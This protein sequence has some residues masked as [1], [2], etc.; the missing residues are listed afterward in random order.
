MGSCGAGTGSRGASSGWHTDQLVWVGAAAGSWRAGAIAPRGTRRLQATA[1]GHPRIGGGNFSSRSSLHHCSSSHPRADAD[2]PGE[3]VHRLQH[4]A[5]AACG[6]HEH[7][8]AVA[9]GSEEVVVA[10]AAAAHRLQREAHRS[11][12]GIEHSRAERAVQTG[13][14]SMINCITAYCS[15]RQPTLPHLNGEGDAPGRAVWVQAFL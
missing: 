6:A 9:R 13:W 14:V 8:V 15:T 11:L 7:A 1:P 4:K 12:L 3:A 5:V 2:L 10:H